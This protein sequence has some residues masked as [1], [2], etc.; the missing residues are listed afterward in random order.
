M[1][2]IYN[3]ENY[4]YGFKIKSGNNPNSTSMRICNPRKI[5]RGMT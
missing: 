3:I 5:I 1:I 4:C 2:S